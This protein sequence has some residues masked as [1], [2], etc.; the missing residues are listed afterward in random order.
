MHP[1]GFHHFLYRAYDAMAGLGTIMLG[2]FIIFCLAAPIIVLTGAPV[3][4][5]L[6]AG[7]HHA[8]YPAMLGGVI[9]VHRIGQSDASPEDIRRRR[10]VVW[11]IV[12]VL[13]VLAGPNA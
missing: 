1:R 3:L 9:A 8:R 2:A 11:A 12:A 13:V 5:V 7:A 6:D 10:R 4:A